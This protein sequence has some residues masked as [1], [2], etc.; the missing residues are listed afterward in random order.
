MHELGTLLGKENAGKDVLVEQI[1]D[2]KV[3]LEMI[4]EKVCKL[5]LQVFSGPTLSERKVLLVR[6]EAKVFLQ[7][8]FKIVQ[9]REKCIDLVGIDT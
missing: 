3:A 8:V 4:L 6:E 1:L 2:P 7:Y 5:I 9:D